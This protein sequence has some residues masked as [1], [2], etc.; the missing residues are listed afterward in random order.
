M[1]G[2]VRSCSSGRLEVLESEGWARVHEVVV[3]GL[4]LREVA[5]EGGNVL[6]PYTPERADFEDI[7]WCGAKG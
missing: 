3:K 4:Q 5:V 1:M 2:G 7:T 6:C